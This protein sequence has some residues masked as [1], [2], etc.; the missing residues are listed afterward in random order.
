MKTRTY[1]ISFVLSSG[2]IRSYST[3]AASTNTT[4][5]KTPVKSVCIGVPKETFAGETR[6]SLTPIVVGEFTK[7]G[8]NIFVED[9]AGVHAKFS[10]EDYIKAGAKIVPTKTIWE[11]DIVLK[12]RPPTTPECDL[13]K[14]GGTLISIIQPGLNKDIVAKLKDRKASVIAL[15][16]IPRISKAQAFDILSSMANIAGYKAVIEAANHFPRFLTGQIT[17]AGKVTPGKILVIGAGVAGLAACGA[18]KNMGAVVRAFDTRAAAKEQVE[19]FGAQ[20]LTIDIKETGDG[21]GGYSK[22]MSKEFIEAEH[23]LFT[24]QCKEVDII[25]TTALIPG[26]KAPTLITKHMVEQMKD[27]SVIVDLAAEAGGN[28]ETTRPNETYEIGR[29]SCRERV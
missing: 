7:Q 15:D 21:A 29:A 26:K 20:F 6:V 24:Q 10:N 23:K 17:A 1:R 11:Q 16:C 27:G 8:M 5:I 28:V 13:V 9:G 4:V 2:V 18:A 12:V 14:Q 19:S 25:I 22:E 3:A